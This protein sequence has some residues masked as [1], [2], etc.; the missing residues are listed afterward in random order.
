MDDMKGVVYRVKCK[1]CEDEYIGETLRSMKVRM[2]E[3]ER[4][5]RFGRIDESAVAEHAKS[6]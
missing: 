4:H 1:D 6:E 5:M 2:K 3:H